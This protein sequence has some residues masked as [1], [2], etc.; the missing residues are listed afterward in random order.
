MHNQVQSFPV[1]LRDFH[2]EAKASV[3]RRRSGRM[4]VWLSLLAA[5]ALGCGIGASLLPATDARPHAATNSSPTPGAGPASSGG[6]RAYWSGLLAS[7]PAASGHKAWPVILNRAG[8]GRF[9]A[10]LAIAEGI[11]NLPVD[12]KTPRTRLRRTDLPAAALVQDGMLDAGG[13]V[14]EH[15]R[16]PALRLPVDDDP[17]GESVIGAD[18]LERSFTIEQNGERLRLVP[19]A[20]AGSR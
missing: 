3:T 19:L 13:I 2:A 5:L 12:P 16:L 20:P 17:G 6:L 1:N 7:A 18:L 9:H 4:T 10:D 15:V 11:V 14:L 8:D